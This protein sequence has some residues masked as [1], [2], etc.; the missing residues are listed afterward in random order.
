MPED[1]GAARAR[2]AAH[3]HGTRYEARLLEQLET[4]LCFEDP[5]YVGLLAAS[6]DEPTVHALALFGEVAGARSVTKLHALVG[7]DAD[8]LA[9]LVDALLSIADR[10]GERMILAEMPEDTLFDVAA[11]RLQA[12]GFALEGIVPDLVS[13]GVGLRLFVRRSRSA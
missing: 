8:A 13:D 1:A 10:S 4:A 3:L 5:E 2:V 9:L 6:P 12:A 11:S 7:E